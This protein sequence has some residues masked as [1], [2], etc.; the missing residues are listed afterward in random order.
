[1]IRARS[2]TAPALRP[3]AFGAVTAVML[4][5]AAAGGAG[6]PVLV[7]RGAAFFDSSLG[8]I[9]PGKLAD[10]VILSADPT[11]DIRNLRR[12]GHV[13]RG[14]VMTNPASLLAAVPPDQ[15]RRQL[16]RSRILDPS[17]NP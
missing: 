9:E 11:A 4:A 13:I 1:M 16:P 15:M 2:S 3:A 5:C 7:L 8:S 12:I 14:G 6:E 17:P 10:L